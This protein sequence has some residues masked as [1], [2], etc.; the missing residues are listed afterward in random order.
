LAYIGQRPVVG[1]YIKLD[2]ISSGFNG[3]NTDF[4]MTA[5]SQAVFPGT[6][7]NLLLSLGGVIQ[8]PDTDFTISG[9]TLTFTTPPVSNTTFFGVIYGD[10]QAIGTPSDGTVLPISIASSGN[11]TFPEITLTGDLTIP[12]KLIHSGDT[13]TNIRFPSNNTISAQTAGSEAIR[14]T[15]GQKFLIGSTSMRDVGGG[16]AQSVFQ[17]EGTSQNRSS[18][19]LINNQASASPSSL[20]LGKTRGTSVGAVDAV[21]D[22]DQLGQIRFVGSDGTDLENTTAMIVGRVNGTVSSNTIPT[23][24]AFETSATNGNSRAERMR[25]TSSGNVGIGIASP[26]TRL[27]VHKASAGSASSDNNSVLTLENNNHCILQM[28]SPASNSN[29]IMFGDPDDPDTG[30]LNYDHN[31]NSFIIKTAAVERLRINSTGRVGIGSSNPGAKLTVVGASGALTGQFIQGAD[32]VSDRIII[33]QGTSGNNLGAFVD[34]SNVRH[35]VAGQSDILTTDSGNYLALHTSSGTERVRIDNDGKVGIGTSTPTSALHIST[36]GQSSGIRLIDSSTS[37]GTPNLEIIGKR[38]DSNGN[39]AFAANIYLGKNRTDAK[40]SSGIILGTINFGGNHTDGSESNISYSAAIRAVASDSFDS[41]TDMPTDLV[42][43]TGTAGKDRDGELAGQSNPGTEHMRL[44][45]QGALCLGTNV[46]N[47][48]GTKITA[49]HNDSMVH[50]T[51]TTTGNKSNIVIVNERATGSTK[52][53]AIIF[54]NAAGSSVGTVRITNTGTEFN[55]TSDYRLK[56][57]VVPISDGITRLKAL[58]PSRFNFIVDATKTFDGFLAHEVTPAVPEAVSG[59]KDAV[60]TQALIDSG[61]APDGEI[62]DQIHQEIDQSKIVPLLT[63]A[64]QEAVA[65]IETLET[66][67]AAL[68]AA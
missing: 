68:E 42:F 40:V 4:N 27:H 59:E 41:K 6:A 17:I 65:K 22:D 45:N 60:I 30:E 19:S 58:K 53:N 54:R 49:V 11:F 56:E 21:T 50:L 52:G 36:T 39:T 25:I 12:D 1:R 31:I 10:M 15:D 16:S 43:C 63:A 8:E 62:G 48:A 14:I 38:Q 24:I 18:I 7:R 23:A 44:T 26:D 46:A 20:R 51:K 47:G 35:L 28:L 3:S 57:N 61:D 37:S 13:D 33:A 67:V 29:R 34:G 64:L 32:T 55:I 2:Q 5:G 9:S 66:K